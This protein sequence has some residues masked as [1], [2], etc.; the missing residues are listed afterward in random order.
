MATSRLR[1]VSRA[2]HT[3]PMPPAPRAD[4]ISYGPSRV[5]GARAMTFTP[6]KNRLQNPARG[7]SG[8]RRRARWIGQHL[9]QERH[10]AVA[11]QHDHQSRPPFRRSGSQAVPP[12]LLSGVGEQHRHALELFEGPR[13][14]FPGSIGLLDLRTQHLPT[15]GLVQPEWSAGFGSRIPGET[16]RSRLGVVISVA[17][18]PYRA[19]FSASSAAFPGV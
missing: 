4:R 8:G 16:S 6:Q 3:S 15:A 2:F 1:R 13:Q 11:I 18:A 7:F 12:C 5:P 10:V 14:S 19:T 17:A 9:H